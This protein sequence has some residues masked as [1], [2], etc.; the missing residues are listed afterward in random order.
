MPGV[1]LHD[2]VTAEDRAGVLA[3]RVAPGQE[4]FVA[5]VEQSFADAVEHP[6][7]CARYWSVYDGD[8]VVGFACAR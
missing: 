3:L 1:E 7:A 6:E 2:I 8:E 5:S 4:Q